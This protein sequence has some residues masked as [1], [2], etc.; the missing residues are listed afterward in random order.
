MWQVLA[1]VEAETETSGKRCMLK[2]TLDRYETREYEWPGV[3]KTCI[4][5]V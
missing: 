2:A 1:I 3:E 4:L 5:V